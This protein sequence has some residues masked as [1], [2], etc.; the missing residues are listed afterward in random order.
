ME[1]SNG[2]GVVLQMKNMGIDN[3]LN[4]P[5]PTPPQ[6]EVVQSAV[7]LLKNLGGIELEGKQSITKLGRTLA[8]FPLAPRFAKMYV[9][10]LKK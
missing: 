7:R 6:Q 3:V 9:F 2:T 4:F 1:C 5:F 10:F 8:Y